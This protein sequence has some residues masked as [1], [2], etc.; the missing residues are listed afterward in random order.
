MSRRLNAARWVD[1]SWSIKSHFW[2]FG[3][4]LTLPLGGLAAALIFEIGQTIRAETEQRMTQVAA[5]IAADLDRDLQRRITILQTLATSATLAEGDLAGFHARAQRVAKDAKAG[6]FLVDPSMRQ[7][8]NTNVPFGTSLPGYGTPETALRTIE[9]KAPQVSN[10]FIGRVIQRP[11][12]DL[13]IPVT[14]DD[15]VSYV[16]A[17]G[18]EPSLL[19]EILGGQQLPL[20]WI[21]DVVDATGTI[22]ARSSDS[23][24]YVGTAAQSELSS[25]APDTVNQTVNTEGFVVL[26]AVA[27]SRIANWQVAVHVPK[28]LA[29]APV[30]R[31]YIIIGLWSAAALLLTAFLASWFAREMARPIALAASAAA[32]LG[33]RQPIAA[34]NSKVREANELISALRGAVAE[35]SEVE[36]QREFAEDQRRRANIELAERAHRRAVLYRFVD[37]LHRAASLVEVY[38]ATLDAILGTLRC[39]RASIL[40]RDNAGVVRFV[41]WRGLSEA[42]RQTVDG[43]SPWPRDELSPGPITVSDVA[44]ADM[45]DSL[46]EVIRKEGIA[47]LAFI[48]L[49]TRGQ[50]IGKFMTYYDAPH[51]FEEEEL[52]LSQTIARQLALSVDRKRAEETEKMLVAELQHR[53]KNLFAVVQALAQSTL[54]G[55]PTIDEA[56]KAFNSR[57]IVLARAHDRLIDVSWKGIGLTQL[58]HSELAAFPGRAKIEG[59]DVV[60]IPRAAQNFALALHELSTN[61][62]KYGALSTPEGHVL[63]TWSIASADGA[64]I[65]KFRWQE[66]GGPPVSQPGREGFGTSLLKMALG[67]TRID[68]AAEGLIYEIEAPMD[69]IAVAEASKQTDPS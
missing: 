42:Y 44:T 21:V 52:G 30:K 18:L 15:E 3:L 63:V 28:A 27:R 45:E 7:L 20:D 60:L 65:L 67:D 64:S 22:I 49:I 54:R 56:R 4:I 59:H 55:H 5:G 38:D 16:L 57:L 39:D 17:M 25:Q 23:N 58:V 6:I 14:K 26:R 8:L 29:E 2:F 33:R 69:Q 41:A 32:G 66:T 50:L 61:A 53:T 40:L 48:P 51:V 37:R 46:K 13:D 19:N 62:A 35:L 24:K 12:F 68:Y 36:R 31:S 10:F 9:T 1:R 47:A 43:H 34:L 11:V